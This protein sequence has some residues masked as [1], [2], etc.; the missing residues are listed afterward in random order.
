M[1]AWFFCPENDMALADGGARYTPPAGALAVGRAGRLLPMLWADE[2][3]MVIVPRREW[4]GEATVMSAD[5]L[6]SLYGARGRVVCEAGLAEDAD[7][8]PWGWSPY[9]RT[10]LGETGISVEQMYDDIAL[11]RIRGLSHRRISVRINSLMSE[12]GIL[13]PPIPIEVR[14]LDE[15]ITL[16]RDY[17]R[18][19]YRG[20]VVKLPWSCS[21]RGV[22]MGDC[23]RIAALTSQIEGMI[24]RQ[25]SV[26]VEPWLERTADFA[27]LFESDGEGRVAYRAASTF[28]TDSAGRYG[29]N[30]VAQQSVIAEMVGALP[31]GLIQAAETALSRTI[32]RDYRGW[33]GMDMMRYT[34]EGDERI[35]PCVEVNLRMTMGVAAYLTAARMYA[36]GLLRDGERRL[37]NV[38]PAGINLTKIP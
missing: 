25:G 31:G 4:Q 35:A 10:L 22:A 34:Y 37:L 36:D 19:G 21:S 29:G 2:D 17:A 3:D 16:S 9:T 33:L 38:T 26:M 6:R 24:R 23:D 11:E 8:M 15:V 32:G 28:V 7:I 1:K 12:S 30:V 20:V 5:R 14:A 18:R 13:L 27:L